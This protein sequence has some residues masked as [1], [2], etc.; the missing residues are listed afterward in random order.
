MKYVVW[1]DGRCVKKGLESLQ[2][3]ESIGRLFLPGDVRCGCPA[4][5]W[6]EHRRLGTVMVLVGGRLCPIWAVVD[7]R[8]HL[9]ATGV[10]VLKDFPREVNDVEYFDE[11]VA[12]GGVALSTP[13][14]H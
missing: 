5:L 13:T 14:D 12:P 11:K 1:R 8:Y 7:G 10:K 4:C 9:E 3:N 6:F 2:G